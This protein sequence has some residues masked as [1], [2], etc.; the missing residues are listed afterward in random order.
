MKSCTCCRMRRER[1]WADAG[2]AF[3]T[4]LTPSNPNSASFD[5]APPPARNHRQRAIRSQTHNPRVGRSQRKQPQ[6]QPRRV[7][8]DHPCVV[9]QKSRRVSRIHVANRPQLFVVA[10]AKAGQLCTPPA[11]RMISRFRRR[12]SSIIASD[13]FNSAAAKI[14]SPAERKQAC[15]ACSTG[16]L[17]SRLP[18]TS[19]KPNSKRCG[20]PAENRGSPLH[21]AT[22]NTPP[23]VQPPP[24]QGSPLHDLRNL[25]RLRSEP[26]F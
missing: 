5:S 7:Q 6:R 22:K 26:E 23:P 20:Q 2:P 9:A 15:A 12:A 8:F 14:C 1:S 21:R 17:V 10:P 11:A 24:A 19:S 16:S 13:S 3:I 4:P 18:A 25:L